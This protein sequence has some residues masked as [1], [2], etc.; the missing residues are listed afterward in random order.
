MHKNFDKKIVFL[1]TADFAVA[2]LEA[3]AENAFQVVAVVTGADKPAGRG[4]KLTFSPVKEAALKLGLPVLQPKNMKSV[5]FQ[6]EL[7]AFGAD[8]QVVVAFRM[9]PE[10][11]WN[12]PPLGTI[13]VHASLLPNYRG[14]APINWAIINGEKETGVTT[15][16]LQQEVD[17]GDMLMFDK[18]QI[19]EEDTF[20]TLYVR[21][22]EMGAK[23]LVKTITGIF[24]N[25][26][27]PVPQ[28]QAVELRYAPKI[29]PETGNLDFTKP[30]REVFNL[31]RGLNPVPAARF[32]HEGK[33]FKIFSVKCVET[34]TEDCVAGNIKSDNKSFLHIFCR[35]GYIDVL[36]IQAEGKRRMSIKEFF[37]GNKLVAH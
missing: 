12:M 22:K 32:Y 23:L 7:R 26:I 2:C 36:E 29:F 9:M 31:I 33:M 17:T 30:V 28:P 24:E 34:G 11:V 13:N 1:G 35:D 3:L 18:T 37:N 21:L 19:S 16:K 14:A 27:T 25:N 5:E 8:I 4:Q 20:E 10:A 15:F 6:D